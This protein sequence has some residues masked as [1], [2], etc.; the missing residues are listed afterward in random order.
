MSRPAAMIGQRVLFG[1]WGLWGL[2]GM[3]RQAARFLESAPSPGEGGLL[4]G[5]S[6]GVLQALIA[7]QFFY[8]GAKEGRWWL[9]RAWWIIA[10]SDIFLTIGARVGPWRLDSQSEWSLVAI[11]VALVLVSLGWWV[12]RRQIL[13]GSSSGATGA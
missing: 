12:G 5:Y 8:N 7:I 4:V 3:Y 2:W 6:L 11:A 1:F 10:L 13:A 9:W